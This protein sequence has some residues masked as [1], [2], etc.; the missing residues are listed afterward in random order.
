MNKAKENFADSHGHNILRFLL[1]YQV[2]LSLQVKGSVII[3]NKHD[4]YELRHKLPSEL[5][6]GILGNKEISEKS[7]SFMEL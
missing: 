2:F 4:I 3:S 5:R 1:F 6:L 7:Q